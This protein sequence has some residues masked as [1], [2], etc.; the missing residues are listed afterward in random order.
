VLF[1]IGK[2]E[3]KALCVKCSSLERGCEWVGTIGTLKKHVATCGFTLVPC[4]KQCKDAVKLLM[5]KDFKKHLENDCPNRDHICEYCGEKGTYAAI[6]K[7]HDK[8]CTMKP[9]LCP[10][11][12]CKVEVQRQQ[13]SEHI[14]KCRY[15]LIPCKYKSIG[16]ATKMK[17]QEMTAHEQDDQLHLHMALETVATLK[18][19][20]LMLKSNRPMIYKLSDYQKKWDTHSKYIFSDQPFYTHPQGY[21]MMLRVDANRNDDGK[22]TH[23]SVYALIVEGEH[24]T[25]LKWPF[26]GKVTLTLLNQLED[27]NHY[28][29]ILPF[30][31]KSD[32]RVGNG[33]GFPNFIPHSALAHDPVKNTQYLMNDT[34]YFRMSAEAADHKPW[35]E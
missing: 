3:I 7:A 20:S 6:T 33:R 14:N 24:D 8:I 1:H 15:T 34:L 12:G 16:C 10:N 17:R 25:E 29:L 21:H 30:N 27:K 23:V 4:P 9:V 28:T 19:E 2:R 22:G 31:F 18:E 5:K 11:D 32:N 13:V 26:V 35:L